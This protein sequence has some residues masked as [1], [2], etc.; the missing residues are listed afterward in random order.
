MLRQATRGASV[1]SWCGLRMLEKCR[2]SAT[3]ESVGRFCD[4]SGP[5]E[6]FVRPEDS[7]RRRH[8][9]INTQCPK[10]T[11]ESIACSFCLLCAFSNHN[12]LC[13][14]DVCVLFLVMIFAMIK[15][16]VPYRV[17]VQ[18]RI[19]TLSH[20]QHDLLIWSH[21]CSDVAQSATE[22]KP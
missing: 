11:A 2:S 18:N 7:E 1:V 5:H 15:R 16:C 21:Q 17:C 12:D 9:R 14:C 20:Q 4:S 3:L 19:A 6:C 22:D 13:V 10:S 8:E